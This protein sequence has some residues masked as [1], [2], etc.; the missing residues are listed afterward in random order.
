MNALS[1]ILGARVESLLPRTAAAA[2]CIPTSAWSSFRDVRFV[3]GFRCFS[4]RQCH[5]SCHG[6]AVCGA[7]FFSCSS[8]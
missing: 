6:K 2:A 4:E 7:W 8:T 5:T 3:S 1:T